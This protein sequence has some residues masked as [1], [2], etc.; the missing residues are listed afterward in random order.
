V[1][2]ACFFLRDSTVPD[3]EK[4]TLVDEFISQFGLSEDDLAAISTF[5]SSGTL[6]GSITDG[7]PWA[8]ETLPAD[9]LPS[10]PEASLPPPPTE[11]RSL[12]DEFEVVVDDRTRRMLATS[13][14]AF[15]GVVA[16]GPPGC[17]KTTLMEQMIGKVR[18][19]PESFGFQMPVLE[20]MTATP[21]ESW[22][23]RELVGGES[24]VSGKLK[25]SEG[26]ILQAIR[27]NRWL[28]LDE[29][30][31]AD[32]D[33]IF[34]ALFTWL[35]GKTVTI[36]KDGPEDDAKTIKLGWSGNPSCSVTEESDARVYLAGDE[37]RLL[38]T[39]N[40]VDAA[41]VFRFGLALGRRFVRVPI[42]PTAPDALVGVMESACTGLPAGVVEAVLGCYRAHF[43]VDDLGPAAF[44]RMP[45]YLVAGDVDASTP[46]N[47]WRDLLAEAY[48]ICVGTWLARFD[49]ERLAQVGEKISGP[50]CPFDAATWD[51][52][53]GTI[54][55]SD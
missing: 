31:R 28:M 39:Y 34:G 44:I 23:T 19:K 10:A 8:P 48:V 36:G 15:S 12:E 29:I 6:S 3:L 46:E 53:K 18:A 1:D 20:P 47:E 52:I 37:W 27:Q 40:E 51:W 5:Q 7:T 17:G 25:F 42:P 14:E 9:W 50:T 2:L 21:D 35:S 11:L 4:S 22:T 30:N 49:D 32:M 13:I 38:G 43:G 24:I 55:S 33:R 26:F 16:V 41:R 45:R 54:R